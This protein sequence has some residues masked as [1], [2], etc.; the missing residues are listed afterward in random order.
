MLWEELNDI[1]F[2]AL[3]QSVM[4]SP[5]LEHPNDQIPFPPLFLI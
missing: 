1:T 5:A 3:K 4:N 2:K